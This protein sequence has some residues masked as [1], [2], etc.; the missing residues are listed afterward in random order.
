MKKRAIW[1]VLEIA[2][3]ALLLLGCGG[4]HASETI[5]DTLGEKPAVS[6]LEEAPQKL[7]IEVQENREGELVFSISIEDFIAGFNERYPMDDQRSFL[8]PPDG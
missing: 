2:A 1:I 5:P 6:A 4:A 7:E 3:G 8:S